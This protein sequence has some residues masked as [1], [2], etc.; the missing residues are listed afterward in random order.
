[1]T[2]TVDF[3]VSIHESLLVA[4]KLGSQVKQR[5]G[6]QTLLPCR[7]V[8]IYLDKRNSPTVQKWKRTSRVG[9]PRTIAFQIDGESIVPF[10]AISQVGD[11]IRRTAEDVPLG[12]ETILN[13]A[14]GGIVPLNRTCQFSFVET[15]PI[16]VYDQLK[17]HRSAWLLVIDHDVA[18]LT[19]EEG[20]AH[21]EGMPIG[22]ELWMR[23][24]CPWLKDDVRLESDTL[25]IKGHRFCLTITEG[26]PIQ[27]EISILPFE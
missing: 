3:A 23:L 19:S 2:T 25:D 18:T 17:R 6:E 22:M 26:A 13:P 15:T 9:Q 7:D 21:F 12:F 24:S 1:M 20:I 10:V 5:E 11:V 27:H 16:E 8:F 14:L 4:D